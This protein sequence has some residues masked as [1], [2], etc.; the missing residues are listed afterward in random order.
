V[1]ANC[2][3]HLVRLLNKQVH[4]GWEYCGVQN[5]TRESGDNIEANKM[6]ELFQEMFQNTNNWLT[7]EQVH[8]YHL[9][10]ARHP[11]RQC[12]FMPLILHQLFMSHVFHRNP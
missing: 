9:Q 4:P 11:A 5:P 10:V 7:P 8:T 6:I 12:G 3:V 2:L 1:V